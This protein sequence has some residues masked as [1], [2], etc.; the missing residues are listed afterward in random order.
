[1]ATAEKLIL[2]AEDKEYF[3]TLVRSRT[4]QAQA[5]QRAKIV[6]LKSE[7]QSI[8]YIADKLDINRK[9]VML[10]LKKYKEG[11]AENA[12]YD[13]PGRGRNSD[14]TGEERAWIINVACKRPQ[15][16]G[17]SPQVW[18]YSLLAKHI[19]ETAE[20]SG[21]GRLSTISRAY[22]A[23]VLQNAN[24][25]PFKIKYYLE[26]RDERFDEKMH[27]ILVV[28]KQVEMQFNEEGELLPL[29]PD[30]VKVNTVSYDEKPGIQAIGNTAPDRMPSIS[31]GFVSRDS[32]YARHGTLS[33]LAGIDLLTGEA[34]PL[35][36]ET[37]KS[38]DFISF[39]KKLDEKYPQGEK[40]RLILDNHSAHTSKETRE[41]LE[42]KPDRF[43]L[44]FTPTHGSW[45]N[46]IEGFFSKMAKQMLRGIRVSSKEDLEKRI[47]KY[48]EEVNEEP[49]VF[50]WKYKMDKIKINE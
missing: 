44:V 1:M 34:I 48:F 19:Q 24:I 35:A 26:R 12:I 22:I 25:K 37:H 7:G 10:C 40:I 50:H 9:S 4:V 17:Y 36:S 6:L 31:H 28:Y 47:Y 21:Y 30:A 29:A 41:F 13:A 33:L 14:V 23:Q 39:L 5:V 15:D 46:M 16:F 3:E 42:T 38:S 49:V 27:E 43:E 18:T 8:E 45:L 2:P 11:G 32:E 20:A